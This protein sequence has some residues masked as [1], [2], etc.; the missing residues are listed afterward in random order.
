M[1]VPHEGWVAPLCPVVMRVWVPVAAGSKTG[2][3]AALSYC[4]WGF[5][6]APGWP[7]VESSKAFLKFCVILTEMDRWSN[8]VNGG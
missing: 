6:D 4:L 3:A 8:S 2:G 5:S 1:P 7:P